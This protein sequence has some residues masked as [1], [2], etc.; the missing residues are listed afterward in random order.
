MRLRNKGKLITPGY[1]FKELDF[2]KIKSLLQVGII[3]LIANISIKGATLFENRLICKI[4]SLPVILYK[5]L[6]LIV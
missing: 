3:I 4:K 1:P 2:I 6:R 5:K